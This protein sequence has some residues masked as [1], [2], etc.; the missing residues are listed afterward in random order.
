VLHLVLQMEE[1]VKASCHHLVRVRMNKRLFDRLKEIA[2]N[3]T[4]TTG[5]YVSVSDIIRSACLIWKETY[6]TTQKLTDKKVKSQ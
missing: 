3:E 2:A 4:Q 1:S 6:E 5:E